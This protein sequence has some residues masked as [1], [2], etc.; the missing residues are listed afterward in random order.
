MAGMWTDL[1]TLGV[2]VAEKV[3]RTIVVYVFLVAGLRLFG[4]RE[5]GQLNPLDFIV[6]L[7]LSNTVQNAII[8]NDNSLAGGL[9]GAGV[10]FVIN[11][12]LVRY[13][14][15][16]PRFRRFVEG[17]PEILMHDGRIIRH[18][19]ERNF[20]TQEELLAAARKQGVQHLHEVESVR[21]EVSGALSF[22]VKEPTA[23]D[24]FHAEVLR[25][26]DAIE[27][28]L[29][30]ATALLLSAAIGAAGAFGFAPGV[31]RAQGA[32]STDVW[33]A[34]LSEA[35][36]KVTV[37]TPL[38]V[39]HRRGYDNQ[40]SF[41]PDGRTLLY[42]AIGDDGEADTWRIALPDGAPARVTRTAIGVYSP[43]VMPDGRTF[44]VIRVELD[45]TQR[46]WKF[47]L[48]G[49]E[50]SLVLEGVKPVGYHAWLDGRTV[51]VY[52]LGSPLNSPNP[53]PATLQVVD[54]AAGAATVV[55]TNIGR[56]LVKV[57]GREAITFVQAVRDSGQWV[58]EYDARTRATKRVAQLPAGADYLAWTPGGSL[59][60]A[61]GATVY[62]LKDDNAWEAVAE[63]SGVGVR[64]ISRLAVSPRGDRIAF[65]AV[66]TPR[67]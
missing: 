29:P 61:S 43:T 16:R 56:A 41:T 2:P 4:K 63:M 54:V 3:A 21:L 53:R 49:G 35:G 51:A 47:P 62:R 65:V 12:L 37:G 5:L 22:V 66:D 42:T 23:A 1:M 24:T 58:T 15:R 17:R 11:D 67:P 64:G 14:Y 32:A 38:N 13:A 46:L 9:L 18:A 19:L 52:V 45:S 7:L 6:L 50:P 57:P 44:S 33:I 55:T 25:R 8:G 59:L 31:A 30:A 39:T 40:P 27:R 60:T 10:L 48:G 34:P 26:L 28:R 36:G 20:I